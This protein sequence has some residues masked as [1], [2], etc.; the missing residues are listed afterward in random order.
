MSGLPRGSTSR[1]TGPRITR[2]RRRERP[3]EMDRA[4]FAACFG[5]VFEH[6]P[7]I[8][9]RA[10]DLELGPAHD[11][12]PGCT[13][14]WRACSAR[15]ARRAPRCADRPPGP[16]GQAGR[17]PPADR[18]VDRRAGERGAGRAD[19]RRARPVHDPQQGLCRKARLSLHHRRA[20]PRQGRHPRRLQR[21]AGQAT[22]RPNSPRHA[23]RWNGSR[24]SDW[25][26]CFDRQRPAHRRALCLSARRPAGTGRRPR[27]QGR[28]HRG[29]R[30]A[31][32]RHDARH[33]GILPA[34]W[35]DTAPGSSPG[36]SAALRRPSRN[37]RSRSA[38]AADPTRRSR[39]ARRRRSCS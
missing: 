10:F 25:R 9:E 34:G 39:T 31:A 13:T 20:R 33:R 19:R 12:P 1:G 15:L 29:L 22:P 2:R 6:S 38:P 7:W 5:D 21:R 24:G 30:G 14:R 3:S 36:R 23:G 32:R 4:R 35:T 11:A 8:A 28:L 16:R 18:G 17:R 26:R 27:R 37:T